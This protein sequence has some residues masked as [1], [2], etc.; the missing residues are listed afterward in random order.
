MTE[1][2]EDQ[3]SKAPSVSWECHCYKT[4]ELPTLH[5][6]L[7]RLPNSDMIKITCVSKILMMFTYNYW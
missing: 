4:F 3:V 2:R 5:G 6:F 1:A 7:M